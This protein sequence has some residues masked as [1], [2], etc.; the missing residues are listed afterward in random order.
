MDWKEKFKEKEITASDAIKRH[1]KPGDRIFIDAACS[2]PRKLLAELITQRDTLHDLEILHFLTVGEEE[3]EKE[4]LENLPDFFRYNV[5]F[6]G[7]R[8][9]AAIND[10]RADY[11]PIH[12]SEAPD[13]FYSGRKHVDV[14][15]IQT[16]IPDKSGFISLGINV[17]V[18]K[19]ISESATYVIAE[20]NPNMPR[21]HGDSFL[22]MKDISHF[23]YSEMP[24]IEFDMIKSPREIGEP[25]G[26]YLASLIENEST[27]QVGLGKAPST[28]FDYLLEKKNLGVHSDHV[29]DGFLKL[30]DD[31]VITCSKK[32]FHKNHIIASYAIGT[33]K[34]Y[35]YIDDN[36][37]FEFYPFEYTNNPLNIAK[38]EKMV[39]IH[40]AL[41]VDL[42]GQVNADSIGSNFY[43]GAGSMLDF[44]RGSAL[45][46][47]GKPIIVMPSTAKN[48]LIS[49]IVPFIGQGAR[50]TVPMLDV[51]YVVSE[52]GIAHLHGKSIRDRVLAMINI[53][54]PDFRQ[55]LLD[56]AKK[57]HYIFEDQPIPVDESG[58]V[59]IYPYQ[60]ETKF[61]TKDGESIFFRPIKPTDEKMVQDLY[62]SLE[63]EAR[64]FRF[65]LNKRFFPRKDVQADVNIDYERNIALVGFIGD[66][67]KDQELIAM[68]SYLVDQDTNL[69]EISFTVSKKWRNQG[70]T[71]FMLHYLIRIAR[72]KGLRGFKGDILWENQPMVHIIQA[73]GYRIYGERTADGDF[74]FSF[75][76][77]EKGKKDTESE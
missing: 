13:L 11:T 61:I 37:M 52:Y 63:D 53:A 49:R 50:V 45:S 27:I 59:V 38:N 3:I 71:T 72:E 33:K 36:P 10:G 23:V 16:S 60:Y 26:H 14:A 74:I 69:G 34:L 75:N 44:I 68:C 24:L 29:S 48:G 76:F 28:V 12:L 57:N 73:S 6:I 62:Y 54:H 51:H 32:T 22:N 39:S 2:V 43:S 18:A 46:K 20:I 4:F 56:E 21:T 42:T 1:V 31:G 65:F 35:D 40:S 58:R 8:L 55:W 5:L 41:A 15:L 67:P 9:R 17:D 70:I 30:I 7:D 19:S 77:D 66:D 47:G 25:I 64:I